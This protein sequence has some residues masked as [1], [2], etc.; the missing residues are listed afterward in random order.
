MLLHKAI[1]TYIAY[2]IK[3][4]SYTILIFSTV[5]KFGVR[6]LKFHAHKG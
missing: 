5:Q 6:F 4:R 1:C 2:E 3:T